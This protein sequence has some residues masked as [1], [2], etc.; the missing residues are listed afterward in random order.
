MVVARR[1]GAAG[2]S[3]QTWDAAGDVVPGVG[4]LG[5]VSPYG[6][7][8]DGNRSWDVRHSGMRQSMILR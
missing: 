5:G 7:V 2:A 1:G 4:R 3:Y 6:E 8:E